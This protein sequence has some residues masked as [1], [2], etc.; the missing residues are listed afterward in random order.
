MIPLW[1]FP[2]AIACGKPKAEFKVL[3]TA[4]NEIDRQ[5]LASAKAKKVIGWQPKY[6]LEEGL[7]ETV[8]WYRNYFED[9]G[10]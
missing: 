4:R 6:S 10:L 3:G 8:L 7:K 5:Y 1:M 9:K 2:I